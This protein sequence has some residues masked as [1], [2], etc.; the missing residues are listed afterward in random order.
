ALKQVLEAVDSENGIYYVTG[1]SEFKPY[2]NG[3]EMLRSYGEMGLV[4]LDNRMKTFSCGEA[5]V[6]LVGLS[7]SEEVDV[8]D[9]EA[10]YADADRS[11]FTVC[12][13]HSP[14]CVEDLLPYGP[15]LMLSGHT[16]GGQ[17][18]L[19]FFN[20]VYTHMARNG[21]VNDGLY[22]PETLSRLFKRPVAGTTLIVSRGIGTSAIRIRFRCRPE[23]HVLTFY[24][25]QGDLG[26]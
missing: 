6:Q 19:P 12:L 4:N 2:V 10:A 23:I 3:E 7:N 8:A 22:P 20:V 16:H 1:N 14:S 15:D 9:P 24:A 5:R 11:L 26:L 18:K 21:F 25:K 17:V 13:S